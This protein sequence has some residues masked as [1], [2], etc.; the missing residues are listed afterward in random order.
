MH[1]FAN[2]FADNDCISIKPGIFYNPFFTQVEL[3][4]RN[5]IID[6]K[7]WMEIFFLKFID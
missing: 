6:A 4:Q 7:R 1:Y 2:N 3:L 5:C